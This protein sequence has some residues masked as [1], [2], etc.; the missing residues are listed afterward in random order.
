[1]IYYKFYIEARN[2]ACKSTI[3][4]HDVS[5]QKTHIDEL[6]SRCHYSFHKRFFVISVNARF[7]FMFNSD[8]DVFVKS[9]NDSSH[10]WK[11]QKTFRAWLKI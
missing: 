8:F 5:K 6:D 2:N 11:Y 1:M 4:F 3:A 9:T 10:V 7:P